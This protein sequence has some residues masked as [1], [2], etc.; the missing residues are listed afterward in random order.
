MIAESTLDSQKGMLPCALRQTVNLVL[1]EE[2]C[3][4]QFSDPVRLWCRRTANRE[5]I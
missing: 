3:Q 2:K 4:G 5:S 1:S